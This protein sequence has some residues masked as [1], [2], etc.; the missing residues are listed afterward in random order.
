M[1]PRNILG[2][3]LA[4]MVLGLTAL[5]VLMANPTKAPD[6]NE[7]HISPSQSVAPAFRIF[8]TA[9]PSDLTIPALRDQA[10]P[11]GDIAVEKVVVDNPQFTKYAVRYPSNGLSI[12]ALMA[13]PKGEGPFPAVLLNHGFYMPNVYKQGD[14]TDREMDH[15]SSR[16]F[17][18]LA[19]DYRNHAG[20]SKTT[21]ELMDR[22]AYAI[23][24]LNAAASLKRDPRVQAESLGIWGHSMGGEVSQRAAAIKP[25]WFKAMV[26][27]GSMHGDERQNAER[28]RF[29]RSEVI[30]TWEQRYGT[31]ASQPQLFAELSARS[32][33]ADLKMPIQIHHATTDEQVPYGWAVERQKQLTDAGNQPQLFTYPNAP[34]ILRGMEWQTFIIRNE[35]FFNATLKG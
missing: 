26:L 3:V 10:Y 27:Y 16:G 11:G 28:I 33:D 32:Y 17:V 9:K 24:V 13:V 8:S 34:H 35:A 23:D 29:W 7:I 2:L 22:L 5:V 25:D 6:T 20:S 4:G 30:T 31:I 1:A 21:G 14:G 19:S 12:T 15:L 18:T